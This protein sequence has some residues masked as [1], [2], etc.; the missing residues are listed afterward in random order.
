M[1]VL[2]KHIKSLGSKK[3]M[4]KCQKSLILKKTYS[5]VGNQASEILRG[6]HL[7]ITFE[8]HWKFWRVFSQIRL[9]TICE[10]IQQENFLF[11]ERIYSNQNLS[12]GKDIL[13]YYYLNKT[14]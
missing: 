13:S 7:N 5:E 1:E 6:L 10:F 14:K 9:P 2:A 3:L 8:H 4:T 12:S 11:V